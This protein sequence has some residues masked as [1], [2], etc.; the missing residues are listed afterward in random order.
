M[1]KITAE[2]LDLVMRDEDFVIYYDGLPFKTCGGAEFAHKN[3][4]VLKHILLKLTLNQQ[5]YS[6]LPGSA[7]IFCF[8]KDRIEK[9]RDFI[10]EN[11][12]LLFD[13]DFVVQA[14]F[15]N[16]HER[17]FHLEEA[18][19]YLDKNQ[20][21]MN[22]IFWSN[23]LIVEGFRNLITQV[24]GD[25]DK[26]QVNEV[27]KEN[28][29]SLISKKYEALTM[30][31]KAGINLLSLRHNNGIVLPLMLVLEIISPS[32]YSNSTMAA[33]SKSAYKE[34]DHVLDNLAAEFNVEIMDLNQNAPLEMVS[35]IHS[36]ALKTM[37]FLRFFSSEH[38]KISVIS[39]LISRGEGD[40][41]EFKSTFRWDIRQ[42]KKNP[43]IEHASLKTMAAFLNSNG[44]DLLIGVED[45]G[46][47]LGVESDGFPNDDKFLLNLWSLI[48]SSMG[49]EISPYLK[50]TLEKFGDRTVCRVHCLQSPKP[51]FLRQ[52]G[53]DESFYIRIGPSTGS[54]E[55]SEALKYIAEHFKG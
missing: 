24:V 25:G 1:N 45:D 11:F 23:S 19:E 10:H 30:V 9:N 15:A 39:E 38:R 41:L 34:S 20:D 52:K 26:L 21:V 43:A 17:V 5:A 46:N 33:R 18:L 55:I 4:R 2:K 13:D 3:A 36:E 8:L 44:G 50:T 49:Q 54:L 51:V 7:G 14:K 6:S 27:N 37:E 42:N 47:I 22:L 31:Q 12:D 32:E 16:K 53:F 28:L 29:K 40:D 48:K 35:F